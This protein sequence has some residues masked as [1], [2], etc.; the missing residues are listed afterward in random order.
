[1]SWIEHLHADVDALVASVVQRVE[2]ATREAI[3]ARGRAVLALAGGRTPLPAYRQLATRTIDW[4]K[5]V[6]MPTDERCVP[7][8]H[9]ACNLREMRTALAAADGLRFESLTT[10][11]GDPVHSQ[12]QAREMLMRHPQAFDAV[13]LGMGHDA[14]TA[15]LFPGATNLASALDPG[16]AVDACRIDP[17]PPPVE[18]PF[19]RITLTA[20]RL[21]RARSLHLVITGEGKH[22]VLRQAQASHDPLHHP[23][24]ALL[25]APEAMV[26]IHWSA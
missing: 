23:I 24:A 18:A 25:H 12:T 8:E 4:R 20:A 26:H 15:S 3:A 19:P 2:D 7:H 1:M 13:V 11:D 10:A 16:S 21:L 14:H 22:E 17:D 9:P 6:A 5:V